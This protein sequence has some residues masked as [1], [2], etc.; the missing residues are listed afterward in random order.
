MDITYCMT[1]DCPHKKMC[2]RYEDNH[3]LRGQIFSI[4]DFGSYFGDPKECNQFI[5]L[6]LDNQ[7]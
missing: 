7:N 3:D 6:A 4:A 5:D 1:K 2:L